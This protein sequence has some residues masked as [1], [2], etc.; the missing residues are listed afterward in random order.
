M[1]KTSWNTVVVQ[2]SKP[3]NMNPINRQ[4][5]DSHECRMKFNLLIQAIY[6]A[7]KDETGFKDHIII[8]LYYNTE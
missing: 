5:H 1:G 3:L 4:S 6:K 8:N 7:S 2:Q